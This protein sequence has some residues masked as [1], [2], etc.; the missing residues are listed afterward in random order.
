MRY[1]SRLGYD[2]DAPLDSQRA[3]ELREGTMADLQKLRASLEG[4]QLDLLDSILSAI[5]PPGTYEALSGETGPV[6]R[7]SVPTIDATGGPPPFDGRPRPGG[8]QDAHTWPKSAKAGLASDRQPGR[9]LRWETDRPEILAQLARG[10][11]ARS[12]KA[13]A[14]LEARFPGFK[15]ART[16]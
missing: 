14:A 1:N 5:M 9:L 15:R 11:M 16:V 10:R 6:G 3:A 13:T 12:A 4:Q 2:A 8:G 7:P